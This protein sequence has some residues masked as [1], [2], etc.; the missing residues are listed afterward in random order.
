M[1]FIMCLGLYILTSNFL[2]VLYMDISWSNRSWPLIVDYFF[3]YGEYFTCEFLF[4]IYILKLIF[5]VLCSAS[6]L[7]TKDIFLYVLMGLCIPLIAYLTH[8]ETQH[9]QIQLF[10]VY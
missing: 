4:S 5:S 1:T 8:P 7:C 10:N 2:G 9:A 3:L 6:S